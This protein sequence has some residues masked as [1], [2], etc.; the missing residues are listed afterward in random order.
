MAWFRS[1]NHVYYSKSY[2]ENGRVRSRFYGRGDEAEAAAAEDDRMRAE[3][4]SIRDEKAAIKAIDGLLRDYIEGV[5]KLRDAH[6]E[7]S[8]FHR[9]YRRFRR[10]G[11]IDRRILMSK[12]KATIQE[13]AADRKL[14][15]D[16]SQLSFDALMLKYGGDAAKE[17]IR[18][19]V[20]RLSGN[21]D[22]QICMTLHAGRLANDL[23]GPDPTPAARVMAERCVVCYLDACLSDQLAL[24]RSSNI[25]L[26][27]FYHD[28]QVKSQRNFERAV[29]SLARLKSIQAE[30]IRVQVRGFKVVG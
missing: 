17:V 30:T 10:T 24:T 27:K 1:G 18:Q 9:H 2:R 22:Q 28:R 6:L 3:K 13:E 21:P 19:L 16:M 8:G 12:N 4:K 15:R 7:L 11:R 29:E 20:E 14:A 25:V 5:R 23:A 26:S